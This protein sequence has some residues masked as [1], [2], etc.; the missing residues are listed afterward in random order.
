MAAIKKL[1]DELSNKI[2][3]GEVVERPASIV[4]ELIENAIDANS[5]RIDIQIEEGGLSKIRVVDNGSGMEKED[6][7]IAFLRH[8]TSKIQTEKDLFKIATLGFRGEAL[9]SIAAVSNLEL[10]TGTGQDAGTL[11]RYQG[12]KRIT[13]ASAK[14]RK[15]TEI[16]VRDLFFNTPAR[17]KYLKTINTEIGN[18]SDIVNRLA[19]ANPSVSFRLSHNDRQLL[20]TNGN[21]DIQAVLAGIYG[22]QT[23][24][25]FLKINN[26]SMDYKV[27]G[28]VAKPEINR[29]SRQYISTFI[30][31]RYVRHYPLVKAI[32]NAYHTLLPIGRHPLVVLHIQMDPV[33]IDVNVH[34]AKLEVRI[35]KE[36]ELLN[37]IEEAIK[38]QLT[39]ETLIPDVD[40][41][42]TKRQVTEQ[43]P[44]HFEQ[45]AASPER[46]QKDYPVSQ[47][48][49]DTSVSTSKNFTK[50]SSPAV[51]SEQEYNS[52]QDNS[53]TFD[54][55]LTNPPGVEQSTQDRVPALEPIGQ[56]HGTYILSQNEKGLYIIDQHAAQERIYYEFYRDKIGETNSQTQDLIIPLTLE[57]SPEEDMIVQS[58][59]KELAEVGVFLEPFGYRTYRVTTYP[60]WFPSGE[61][62]STIR[63]LLEQLMLDKKISISKLREDAA[64]LMSCKAAIKANRHL[65]ED[66]MVSLIES[67]RKCDIPFTCPHGR[68]IIIHF[69][70]YD[71]E[72]MFKRIM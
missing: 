44:L 61:E 56:M 31:G 19:L 11:I 39:Q 48:F 23:A 2:A 13:F 40:Q 35:S 4:K 7:K 3:A 64:I 68:P 20:F 62:E 49:Y 67:L 21:G 36:K 16:T 24:S 18:I 8:A 45:R 55:E 12:G 38:T 27:E 70:S 15:G 34:P 25:Q 69:S 1:S 57:L 71:M 41:S 26:Q 60:A 72:K 22:R 59:Q 6:A 32:E 10:E 37:I 28:Y 63:E 33:L 30:N 65:R 14:G 50:E 43:V 66:E 53:E 17:L 51:T 29:A 47:Q 9:P 52:Y 42:R 46:P 54:E 5:T 58:Y